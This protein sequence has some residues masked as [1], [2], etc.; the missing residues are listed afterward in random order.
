MRFKLMTAS[1]M[2]ALA[3]ALGAAQ[4]AAAAGDPPPQGP[5]VC[6]RTCLQGMVDQ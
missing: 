3:L 1:A 2:G 5:V 4:P 6:D